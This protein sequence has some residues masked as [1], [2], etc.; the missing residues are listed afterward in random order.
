MVKEKQEW[1][2]HIQLLV[3]GVKIFREEDFIMLIHESEITVRFLSL[4]SFTAHSS[5]HITKHHQLKEQDVSSCRNTCD[6]ICFLLFLGFFWCFVWIHVFTW[7]IFKTRLPHH[8]HF[9]SKNKSNGLLAMWKGVYASMMHRESLQLK[10]NEVPSYL[11][12]FHIWYI[13]S[14]EVCKGKKGARKP[15]G[16]ALQT[17]FWRSSV[18][19]HLFWFVFFKKMA[20][21]LHS[22]VLEVI[23]FQSLM[24]FW[25]SPSRINKH[26]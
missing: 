3:M 19:N 7:K 25:V 23:L 15:A 21:A 14:N 11:I 5:F 2:A 20:C 22:Q 10:K 26:V 6:V 24:S 13:K 18:T 9:P 1:T 4:A 12:K 17:R 8:E 16:D